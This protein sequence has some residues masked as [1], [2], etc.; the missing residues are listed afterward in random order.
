MSESN[1]HIDYFA[2][3]PKYL[4]GNASDSEVKLLEDWVLADSAN[5]AQFNAF[6][7]AWILSAIKKDDQQIDV[8]QEWQSTSSQLFQEAKTV[9]LQPKANRGT[10]FF[11]RI[12]AAVT[13]LMVA[14]IWL[15]QY[16]NRGE[17]M[18]L[19]TQ[20][21]VEDNRLPD[22]S[23]IAMN[24][25]SQLKYAPSTNKKYRRVE[26]SGDAFFEVE[27]DT[28]R[29]FVITTQNVEIEVLG[30]AF[31]VD[32]REDQTQVQVIVQSGT[33]SVKAGSQQV[34]L[35]AN[36]IG[37]YDKAAGELTK[38]VNED[39]NYM[40][41][42]TGFLVF[43]NSTLAQ[44]VFDLNRKFHSKISIARP[45][46]K[47]CEITAN[48]DHQSLEATVKIIEKTL[49]IQAERNGEEIVFSGKGCE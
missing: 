40:A 35:T 8:A 9:S 43:E 18:E 33:V 15:F 41:W 37:I 16:L 10:A 44:V 39:V 21:T 48:F 49:H 1:T 30:T 20:N 46:L 6:K 26:L 22:G 25:Y 17:S 27:R 23:Q 45:E 34:I 42:K 2:L 5:K 19:A 38:K 14:S 11:F 31:Y 13:V 29:P 12:A 47:T 24:Q 32:A 7:K 36:E 3:I 28:A 4:S